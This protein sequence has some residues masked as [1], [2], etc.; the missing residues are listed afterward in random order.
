MLLAAALLVIHLGYMNLAS[1]G[2]C[3]GRTFVPKRLAYTLGISCSTHRLSKYVR[4]LFLPSSVLQSKRW[5]VLLKGLKTLYLAALKSLSAPSKCK[6]HRSCLSGR[7]PD[8]TARSDQD[9]GKCVPDH[10]L[11]DGTTVPLLA[12]TGTVST[13]NCA[14][15]TQPASNIELGTIKSCIPN[16]T[17]LPAAGASQGVAAALGSAMVVPGLNPTKTSGIPGGATVVTET[18]SEKPLIVTYAVSLFPPCAHPQPD[19]RRPPLTILVVAI[20]SNW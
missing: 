6:K 15:S 8:N 18:V 5:T 13:I 3:R 12:P 7:S 19:E 14:Y 1:P 11:C 10:C 2:L 9:K 16:P 20:K 17:S 4:S